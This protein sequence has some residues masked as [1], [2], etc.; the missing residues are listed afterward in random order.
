MA[1]LNIPPSPAESMNIGDPKKGDSKEPSLNTQ[2]DIANQFDVREAM[3][4][5][6]AHGIT[7]PAESENAKA[8]Y[9]VIMG[10]L[11]ASAAQKLFNHISLFNQGN[12]A[13]GLTDTNE[14][15]NRFY[16]NG[17]SD[18]E[19][20]KTITK[21]GGLAG[22]YGKTGF[23]SDLGN[24]SDKSTGQLSMGAPATQYKAKIDQWK[25]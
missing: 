9:Q 6:V 4:Y 14:R 13:K 5:L 11:G 21:L 18:P 22:L 2:G 17:S 7:S 25:P 3:H 24:I 12:D 16:T 19:V 20:Q 1:A 15:L 10:Q 8:M 23:G